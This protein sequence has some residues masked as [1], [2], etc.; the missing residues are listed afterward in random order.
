MNKFLVIVTVYNGQKY[1]DRCLASVVNQDYD[2]FEVIVIDDCSNDKTWSRILKYPVRKIKNLKR[3]GSALANIVS[4]V[5][6][7]KRDDIV[8]VVDG[9]DYL[10]DDDVLSYL[11]TIYSK[12]VWMTHGQ[13]IPES[14]LYKDFCRPVNSKTYRKSGEWCTS[15]L[16][17][18]RKWL[19]D[20]INDDD[21]RINGEYSFCAGDRAYMTL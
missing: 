8:V 10:A 18:F 1:I 12:D 11:S 13:F 4:G 7:G 14:R 17:T 21:L 2:N 20:K 3:R 15:H 6:Y 19:W 5:K 9:D 16:K